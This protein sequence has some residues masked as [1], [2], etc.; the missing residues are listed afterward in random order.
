MKKK[1]SFQIIIDQNQNIRINNLNA[2]EF[3]ELFGDDFEVSQYT[4]SIIHISKNKISTLQLAIDIESTS[5]FYESCELCIRNCKVNRNNGELGWCRLNSEDNIYMAHLSVQEE[6]F[7][8]PTYEIYLSS[9]NIDCSFCH[10]KILME[11]KL[12]N[13]IHIDDIIYDLLMN[14]PTIKTISFVGGNPELSF[15]TILKIINKVFKN[16]INLQ[17]VLNSNFLFGNQL[18]P[19][20]DKYFD[21]L[22]PDFKFWNDECSQ[23][24]CG[25]TEYK[26]IVQN[27]ILHFLN[28]KQMIVRHLPLSGH[29]KCCS[30]P[31]IEWIA[32][33]ITKS[34]LCSVSFLDM[35]QSENS[36]S[37]I[38]CKNYAAKLNLNVT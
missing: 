16:K 28:R 12:N 11:P 21:I 19:F 34:K 24:L 25:F 10:Q 30:K 13:Y 36:R 1:S 29:W 31:I 8:S 27:N 4:E 38:K 14:L 20:I 3:M 17:F 32:G 37:I 2:P 15:L 23:T 33:H 7:I 5:K 26:K 18:Y 22:I 9:C 6:S 35:L